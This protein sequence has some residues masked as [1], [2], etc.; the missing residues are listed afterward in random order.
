V[1]TREVTAPAWLEADGIA[2]A[3][4][5]AEELIGLLPGDAAQF[6]GARAP[7]DGL[8]VVRLDEVPA[9]KDDATL[10]VRFRLDPTVPFAVAP[11]SAVA[12]ASPASGDVGWLKV[13]AKPR[14]LSVIPSS[15]ILHGADGPFVLVAEGDRRSF[16]PRPVRIGRV[17]AGRVALLGGLDEGELIAV[18]NT[19]LLDAERRQSHHLA[20]EIGR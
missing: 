18:G 9:S 15:A 6:F 2:C 17:Y 12:P 8:R 20:A 13:A 7:R 1:F 10:V 14:E 3:L 5:Y 16:I 19:F 4:L 11:P